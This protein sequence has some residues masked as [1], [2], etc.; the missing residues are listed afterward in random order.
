MGFMQNQSLDISEIM[1]E[2]STE[3]SPI[4]FEDDNKEVLYKQ[5]GEVNKE[6]MEKRFITSPADIEVHRKVELQDADIT[7]AQWKAFKDLCTEFNY[8]FSTDPGDIGKT[9]LL[10]VEIDTG[11]SLSITQKPYTLPLKHT[12]WVQRELEIL[13]KAGVI[14]RSI[15]PWASPIVV[16]PKRTAPG[17][18]P[19][20]RLCIDYRTL[21][22]LLPPVK[23]AFSKAKGIITLVPLPKIDEIYARLKGSN[24]YSTFD[25]RS[26]Y[27]HMVLSEKSRPKSAF[28]SSF[29]KWEFKRCPF[30]LAQ[31]PMY[32]QRLVVLS[33]LT[34]AFGY[35]DDILVYSPDMETH[36]EHLRKLFIKLREADLKLKEVKCNFLKKH[37]QYL[38][39][40]FG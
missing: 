2:T 26:G 37:I 40:S 5:E 1:T 15:S 31:A 25:I 39:H 10:E 22:S 20:W 12:A 24:I 34:L 14:V 32:Y 27:Y 33:G 16:V 28:I 36:L 18:P 7:V 29:G 11:D 4:I 17:E 23:K 19:K 21:N 13:E 38:G 9:P 30:G 8:I 35:L 3:P 6:N